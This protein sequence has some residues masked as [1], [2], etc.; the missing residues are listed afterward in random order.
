MRVL[1]INWP[2]AAC[3]VSNSLS[4]G[5]ESMFTL[6]NSPIAIPVPWFASTKAVVATCV[7]FVP[8]V[9]V[10]A[11]G[12]PVRAADANIWPGDWLATLPKP[13]DDALIPA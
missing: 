8:A 1:L 11:V 3:Q 5:G 7:V 4:A 2:D 9:A 10:G 13:I 12:T 6:L